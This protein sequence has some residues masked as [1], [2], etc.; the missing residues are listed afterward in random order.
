MS[1]PEPGFNSFNK[2]KFLLF[3]NKVA[4]GEMLMLLVNRVAQQCHQEPWTVGPIKWHQSGQDRI[5]C[6]KQ[7]DI[8]HVNQDGGQSVS[9]TR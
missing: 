6:I 2:R 4:R 5:N 8:T 9:H 1:Q 7:D 3:C